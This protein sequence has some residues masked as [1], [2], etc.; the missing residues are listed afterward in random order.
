[1][2]GGFAPY[3]SES[4]LATQTFDLPLEN[5]PTSAFPSAVRGAVLPTSACGGSLCAGSA[6]YLA[7]LVVP[8][9]ATSANASLA[10]SVDDSPNLTLR[11]L[12]SAEATGV[13]ITASGFSFATN[14]G[15]ILPAGGECSIGLTGSGPGSVTIR[16]GNAASQMAAFPAVAAGVTQTPVVASPKELDFGMWTRASG[17]VEQHHYGDKSHRAEPDV[18]IRVNISAKTTLPYTLPRRQP[19]ARRRGRAIHTHVAR[20]IVPY[21]DRATASSSSSNDG[22]IQLN[23]M[24]GGRSVI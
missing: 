4:L 9:S 12:G 19:I 1:M 17:V 21:H 5:A 3:A 15:S 16:A 22:P 10:L 8:V 23:W 20:P 24:V 2:A 6:A 14:C 18:Y 7:T 11:N 13:A